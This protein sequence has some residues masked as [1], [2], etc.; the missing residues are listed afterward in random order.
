MLSNSRM[1]K[2]LQMKK[3]NFTLSL[4]F[5]F[6]PMENQSKFKMPVVLA[7]LWGNFH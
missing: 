2:I 4:A 3:F 5:I 7:I 1:V 6:K